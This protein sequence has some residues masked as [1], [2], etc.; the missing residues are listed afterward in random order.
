MIDPIE[1]IQPLRPANLVGSPS[2]PTPSRGGRVSSAPERPSSR[3]HVLP[4]GLSIDAPSRL[5]AP[6]KGA[7]IVSPGYS[8]SNGIDL[9]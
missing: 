3:S 9:S 4:A 8:L 5:E 6:Q 7:A 2:A 1:V